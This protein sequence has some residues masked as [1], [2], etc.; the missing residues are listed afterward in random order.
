MN[1]S[2]RIVEY[3]YVEK[4]SCRL[5]TVNL[6]RLPTTGSGFPLLKKAKLFGNEIMGAAVSPGM[7]VQREI[8]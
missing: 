8:G 3:R 1:V 5:D 7:V 6:G 2:G 4:D